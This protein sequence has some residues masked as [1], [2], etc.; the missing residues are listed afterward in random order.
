MSDFNFV[1]RILEVTD[2]N[3]SARK[4]L[5][6]NED[7]LL[8]HFS[9][10]PVMPGVLMTQ[11]LVETAG[12]WLKHKTDFKA[13]NIQLKQ[14]K[15]ARFANFLKPGESLKI[16]AS[17]KSYGP[18]QAEFQAKGKCEEKVVLSVQFTLNYRQFKDIVSKEEAAYYIDQEKKQFNLLFHRPL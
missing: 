17:N 8:D 7:Y 4:N 3:I 10:Y 12:W 11:S 14:V 16:E 9:G 15:N 5:T 13:G 1:D 6:I 2:T 18:E